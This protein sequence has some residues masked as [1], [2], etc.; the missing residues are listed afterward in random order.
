MLMA[1]QRTQ[2]SSRTDRFLIIELF[3][4]RKAYYVRAEAGRLTRTSDE[5]ITAAVAEG[6]LVPISRGEEL[7]FAW[8]DVAALAVRRWT[9]RMIAAALDAHTS[10]IPSLNQ[11]KHIEVHL[12]LYQ[13]R[14]LHVLSDEGDRE[15]RGQLNVSD[16]IERQLLDLA[17][18]VA[19][20]ME[21]LIPGFRAAFQYPY[22]IPRDD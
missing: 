7:L 16:I 3:A 1:A 4:K 8:E 20:E 9:P 2:D 13:I 5:G 12:P 10:A 6:E 14:M 22:F 17:E 15:V 11:I 18:S 19:D 21:V